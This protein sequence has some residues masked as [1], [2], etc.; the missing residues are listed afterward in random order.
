MHDAAIVPRA[1]SWFIGVSSFLIATGAVLSY[2]SFSIFALP[3][4]KMENR[5]DK[6]PLRS[7]S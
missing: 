4:A 5:H 2:S 3:S 7:G 6:V 1:D